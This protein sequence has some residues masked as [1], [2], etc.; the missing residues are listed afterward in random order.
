MLAKS[1][2]ATLEIAENRKAV[3]RITNDRVGHHLPSGANWLVV[4]LR[5]YDASGQVVREHKEALGREETLLFDF[6]PFNV[7]KRLSFG[8]QREIRL[9]L[10]EG[11]GTVEATVRYHD[12]MR[13]AK[14]VLVLKRDY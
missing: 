12:W 4:Y 9:A 1:V 14:I 7:D 8:E 6:W 13:V 5:A 2:N 10:P 3:F 11:H